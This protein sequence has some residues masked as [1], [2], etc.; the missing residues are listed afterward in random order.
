MYK[1]SKIINQLKELLFIEHKKKKLLI[2]NHPSHNSPPQIYFP[3]LSLKK[4]KK[5]MRL[6]NA[7]THRNVRAY[8]SSA[9]VIVVILY[10]NT[11]IIECDEN[12]IGQV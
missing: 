4:K 7:Y 5:M 11:A 9:V 8:V 3:T 2:N 12:G 1:S 10:I 6:F